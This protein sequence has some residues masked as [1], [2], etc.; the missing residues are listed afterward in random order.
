M[1]SFKRKMKKTMTLLAALISA[2][3]AYS[4]N[5][6]QET[7][8]TLRSY[9]L[10]DVQVVATR[11]SKKTPMAFTNMSQEQIKRL[12]TGRDIPFLLA[13]MPSVVTTS[14]A[15]NGMGYTAMRIRGTDASRINVT[16]NGI[17]MNDAESS[18]LYWVNMGDLASSLGSIQVQRGVGTSTN[19]AGAFGATVNMQTE[20]I[21]LQPWAALDLSGGSYYSH[22]QTVRF[23]TGLMGGHWGIQGRLSNLGSKGYVDRASSKLNSYFLQAGYFGESTVV[24][25]ITF[26][27]VEQTYHAWDFASK[28]DQEQYGRTY[29]PSGKMEK[30]AAGN[31]QFYKNQND[32]YHQQ[33]YQLLWNQLMGDYWNLNLALHYTKGSGYYEQYKKN[34]ELAQYGLDAGATKAK[35]SLV[36]EKWLDSYF[37]GAVA[38]LNYDNKRNFS[39]T[40]GE[41]WNRY[42]NDHFGY[43]TWVKKPVDDFMPKHE[44][45]NNNTKKTDYNAYLKATYEFVKGLSAFADLQ[46]RYVKIRMVGPADATSAKRS[47]SYDVNETFNFFNPKF[48]LNY[49]LSPLHRLYASYAIAHR[50][51]VRS[52]YE[53]NMD[54][55][56]EKPRAERLN[57]LEVGYEFTAKNFTAG[58]NLYHMNYK[59][60]LVPTGEMKLDKPI[61]RNFDKSYR[62]G[63]ELSTAWM[64]V[65][66]FRWDA[67]ATFSKNR[68]KD[69]T[70]ALTD[71]TVY[72]IA[73]ES[74][75][76]FSPNMVFN[77]VFTFDKAGFRGMVM[78][79][80]VGE[81]NLTNTG[82]KTMQTKDADKNTVNDLISLKQYFTT[83]ID[84]S[85]TFSLKA[86]ALKDA[87]IGVT[88]YN[89][90]SSKYDNNGW[91]A[92]QYRLDGS[93]LVAENTWGTRDSDAAGFAP[94]A[95]FHFMVRLGVNF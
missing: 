93:T 42:S 49:E 57:D 72:T 32:N 90:F 30:D 48:G 61:T 36:R 50:E 60:Q 18:M 78:S 81:Q 33:H 14:D 89:V 7:L 71:G 15:G 53:H 82:F 63:V 87:T 88:L 54:A 68:V 59:D 56:L 66:W 34:R 5:P 69:V 2:A 74:Q 28:Y 70:V 37:Y 20:N 52:N 21:G 64:P 3:S 58:L 1:Y 85:Y 77:N 4:A 91:A 12:N 17:P 35:S 10:Q 67:N 84:L 75:L 40:L 8:D 6:K 44:Y 13:T 79:H 16:T 46:Y 11:A 95:P 45:Y 65:D 31:A 94:S 23:G 27:G 38:A 73:G 83:D 92:P 26:N 76:A 80:F 25:F 29:N 19:G 62:M 55:Q 9:Q 47:F 22:K 41:G 51:P 39:A 86:L 24:K 43:V